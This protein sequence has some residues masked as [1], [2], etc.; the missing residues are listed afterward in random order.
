MPKELESPAG[1]EQPQGAAEPSGVTQRQE[2]SWGGCPITL[3]RTTVCCRSPTQPLNQPQ[4]CQ[5]PPCWACLE[6]SHPKL[7]GPGSHLVAAAGP[8]PASCSSRAGP[9]GTAVQ[10]SG[11]SQVEEMPRSRGDRRG[12]P[13]PTAPRSLPWPTRPWR[14]KCPVC[15]ASPKGIPTE[16]RCIKKALL[17]R[18]SKIKHEK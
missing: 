6:Q 18:V 1:C 7:P 3:H 10:L 15:R 8:I 14:Y 11:H 4:P 13:S 2:S 9:W 17:V 5:E 12:C 16:L